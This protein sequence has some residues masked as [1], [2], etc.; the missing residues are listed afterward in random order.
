MAQSKVGHR[1][2]AQAV[3]GSTA[4][5]V[6]LRIM[7][8]RI[9]G[10]SLPRTSRSDLNRNVTSWLVLRWAGSVPSTWV[11]NTAVNSKQWLA[12]FQRYICDTSIVMVDTSP[13]TIRVAW[14]Y[15]NA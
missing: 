12:C 3:F 5:L 14:G 9:F 4:G 10:V 8:C 11:S 15:V 6:V 13:T 2:E 1:W 7:S